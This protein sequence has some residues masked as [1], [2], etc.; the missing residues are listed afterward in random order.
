MKAHVTGSLRV[1]LFHSVC[2]VCSVASDMWPDLLMLLKPV[3]VQLSGLL[4]E[5]HCYILTTCYWT[6]GIS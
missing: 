2:V 4:V 5:C 6:S 1:S 3:N